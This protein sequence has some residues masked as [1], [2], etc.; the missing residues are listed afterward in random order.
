MRKHKPGEVIAVEYVDRTGTAKTVKLTLEQDPAVGIVAVES[1]G[2]SLT[3]AQ[4]AF[5]AA[6]LGR[7]G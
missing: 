4:A 5:R 2:V 1:T 6:W 7:R 3:A